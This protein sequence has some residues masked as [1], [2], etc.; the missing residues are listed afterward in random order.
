M[1]PADHSTRDL[2]CSERIS[3]EERLECKFDV[4]M[5]SKEER[6]F[7]QRRLVVMKLPREV[8]SMLTVTMPERTKLKM[9]FGS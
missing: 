9:E 6:K 1:N 4:P 5:S 8:K 3:R 2:T 7:Q